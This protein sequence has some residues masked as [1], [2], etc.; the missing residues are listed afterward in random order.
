MTEEN[1]EE[2]ARLHRLICVHEFPQS[3]PAAI[4]AGEACLW[5]LTPIEGTAVHLGLSDDLPLTGCAPC[6]SARLAWYVSWYDWH[7]HYQRCVPCQQ[8]RTCYVGHGRRILHEQTTRPAD[9]PQP[10]CFTCRDPLLRAEMAAP[11]LRHSPTTGA[12]RFSYAHM[13]CLTER[14]TIR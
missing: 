13:R 14:A 1:F 12:P 10:T 9:K 4:L 6:Y 3:L 7:E 5:C 2:T 11:L 8:R